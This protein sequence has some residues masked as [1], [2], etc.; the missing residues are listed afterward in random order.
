MRA[1]RLAHLRHDSTRTL[2]RRALLL[3]LLAAAA[4]PAVTTS[5]LE[6]DPVL[7]TP[8][9]IPAP[10]WRA[11]VVA[12]GVGYF[13]VRMRHDAA[14]RALLALA[15]TTVAFYALA[16][17]FAI[18]VDAR[19]TTFYTAQALEEGMA[20]LL[21]VYSAAALLRTVARADEWETRQLSPATWFA[22][23][24]TMLAWGALIGFWIFSAFGLHSPAGVLLLLVGASGAL[25][26]F[27]RVPDALSAVVGA[28]AAGS[29]NRRG[30][31]QGHGTS[32]HSGGS[33]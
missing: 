28:I 22:D 20:V 23:D 4:A 17:L 33:T 8:F 29:A 2:S 7:S 30:Q 1:P 18:V 13:V 9:T 5:S 15:G 21:A 25:V 11:I 12:F 10:A 27:L 19:S 16:A 32:A 3:M 6:G 24:V 14:R 31:R 26:L